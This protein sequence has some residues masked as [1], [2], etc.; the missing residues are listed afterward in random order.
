MGIGR[1][2]GGGGGI[3][4]KFRE[5]QQQLSWCQRG[6]ASKEKFWSGRAKERGWAKSHK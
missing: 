3:D 5:S 1:M 4:G 2:E 6:S